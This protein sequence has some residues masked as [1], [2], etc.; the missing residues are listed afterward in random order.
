VKAAHQN[1][2]DAREN[3]GCLGPVCLVSSTELRSVVF[4][5]NVGYAPLPCLKA[6]LAVLLNIKPE[7]IPRLVAEALTNPDPVVLAQAKLVC[8]SLTAPFISR[9]DDFGTE[10]SDIELLFRNR[11]S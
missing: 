6:E 5:S 8:A 7:D 10:L 3:E 4:G 2:S 1:G 9:E 11:S